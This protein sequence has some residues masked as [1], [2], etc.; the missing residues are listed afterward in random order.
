MGTYRELALN[1]ASA[2]I[3]TINAKRRVIIPTNKDT[4][5]VTSN[6]GT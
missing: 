5:K 6:E 1:G 3:G 4:A 2:G